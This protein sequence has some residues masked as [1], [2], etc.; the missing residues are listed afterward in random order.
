MN[1]GC[2]SDEEGKVSLEIIHAGDA[3]R[4]EMEAGG[5]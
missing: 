3:V 2:V 5:G 1:L 4:G